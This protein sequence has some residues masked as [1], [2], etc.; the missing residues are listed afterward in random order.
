MHPRGVSLVQFYIHISLMTAV[1]NMIGTTSLNLRAVKLIEG[2]QNNDEFFFTEMSLRDS[3][4][5]EVKI[6]LI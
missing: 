1:Q 2:I 4:S 6:K 5:G 3:Q